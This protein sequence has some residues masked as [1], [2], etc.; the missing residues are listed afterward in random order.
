VE[1]DSAQLNQTKKTSETQAEAL[2]ELKGTGGPAVWNWINIMKY[3]M[4]V[5]RL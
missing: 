4:I 5:V 3:V 1:Q 2:E